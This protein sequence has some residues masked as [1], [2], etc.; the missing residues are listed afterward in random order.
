MSLSH[1]YGLE[2]WTFTERRTTNMTFVS[3]VYHKEKK[4][5]TIKSQ[6]DCI[7][8][9]SS[10]QRHN[11]NTEDTSTQ[12]EATWK[13]SWDKY[14]KG[15]LKQRIPND[16]L[17]FLNTPFLYPKSYFKEVCQFGINFHVLF[18]WWWTG[19]GRFFTGVCTTISIICKFKIFFVIC[20]RK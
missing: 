6:R 17:I 19:L 15:T 5:M 11:R 4:Q 18:C 7:C 10:Q 16:L 3:L 14:F 1:S 12:F 9:R 8:P 13:Q 2:L 20:Q